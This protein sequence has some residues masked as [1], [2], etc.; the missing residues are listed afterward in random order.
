M[1]SLFLCGFAVVIFVRGVHAKT[2]PKVSPK[3][4]GTNG[5]TWPKTSPKVPGTNGET[6]PK[7]S[8]KVPGTNGEIYV[9]YNIKKYCYTGFTD[10]AVFFLLRILS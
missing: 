1:V 8:P 4:P 2:W 10:I 5:E 9:H 3:V 6:W 7:V